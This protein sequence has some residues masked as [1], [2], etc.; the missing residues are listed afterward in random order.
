MFTPDYPNPTNGFIQ[1]YQDRDD[2]PSSEEIHLLVSVLLSIL[3][4]RLP[5]GK[6]VT[7]DAI[8]DKLFK[9]IQTV[10]E[11]G[12]EL[13]VRVFHKEHGCGLCGSKELH[14]HPQAIWRAHIDSV[15]PFG[16]K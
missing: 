4:G 11:R 5:E 15:D 6:N 7:V 3:V 12:S 1:R 16:D 13:P 8:T 10:P 9:M 2:Y 14:T